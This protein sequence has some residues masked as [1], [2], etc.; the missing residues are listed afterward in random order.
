[1]F[2]L[3][4]CD[5]TG[6]TTLAQSI[7]SLTGA[8]Y[9]HEGPPPRGQ[10]AYQYYLKK[11]YEI[12]LNAVLDRYHLGQVVYPPVMSGGTE[13]GLERWQ[14]Q[15]IERVLMARGAVLIHCSSDQASI[16]H[17]F[18]ERGED[19]VSHSQITEITSRFS[20]AVDRSIL[21]SYYFNYV[22]LLETSTV[23]M[24]LTTQSEISKALQNEV[25]KRRLALFRD[26]RFK[27]IGCM[28]AEAQP[29][30]LVSKMADDL[31]YLHKALASLPPWRAKRYYITPFNKGPHIRENITAL[32]G[33]ISTVK[34]EAIVALGRTASKALEYSYISH[35]TV[36]ETP[37]WWDNSKASND[38]FAAVIE[39]AA[40]VRA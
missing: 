7:C 13:Q 3:E 25:A 12:P 20:N 28:D 38:Q 6:K 18:N 37:A 33:E 5:G 15:H 23:L 11:A 8:V 26:S 19:Y 17:V 24:Q 40:K 4:G 31:T 10:S 36:E 1:M 27:G 14:Q 39:K 21:E 2:I 32:K 35:T 30:M 16:E 22:N 9:L 34:P 29:I